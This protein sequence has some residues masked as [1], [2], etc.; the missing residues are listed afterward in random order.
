ML[1]ITN[2]IVMEKWIEVFKAGDYP[3]GKFT[4]AELEEIER[5]KEFY[6]APVVI[7]H[8]KD[9]SPAWGWVKDIKKK[10]DKLLAKI[11]DLV[12]EFVEFLKKG[13]YK[14]V[15][16]RLRKDPER[17]WFL[18]HVG[19]LGGAEPQVKG[20]QTV[21]LN[22]E[23]G[24]QVF[25]I[26]F[27]DFTSPPKLDGIDIAEPKTK[28]DAQGAR[29]RIFEKYG[30]AGLKAYSL[31]Y[32]PDACEK[33]EEGYPACQDAY[34]Y[35]VVDL[36]DGEP[37]IIPKAVSAAL[38][39]AH[40]ARGVKVAENEKKK[41]ETAVKK[42][43]KR[44]KEKYADFVAPE[45]SFDW[46]LERIRDAFIKQNFLRLRTEESDPWIQWIFPDYVIVKDYVSGKYWKVA[47]AI[48]GGEIKFGDPKE[49]VLKERF[50]IEITTED[51]N[52][53]EQTKTG[54]E[55]DKEFEAQLEEERKKIEAEFR[56]KIEREKKV[57]EFLKR[58]EKKIPPVVRE[59]VREV[60][61]AVPEEVEFGEGKKNVREALFEIIEAYPDLSFLFE[62]K[63]EEEKANVREVVKLPEKVKVDPE[64]E[65]IHQKALE[66]MAKDKN[67]TYEQAVKLAL[68]EEV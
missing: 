65:K 58:N 14:H 60:L 62:E 5:N 61:M 6:Q 35:L 56:A 2:L 15:S 34:K 16:V 48:D 17:G 18:V 39:Y 12:P 33:K 32:N 67:L 23:E 26:D 44:I 46:Y 4:E 38:A 52:M 51:V 41:V 30:W 19:F 47:Y 21:E 50:L 20:L 45:G 27:V 1:D 42:L 3:Q 9:S 29:K 66:F 53:G 22:A 24:D 37:K 7:G 43:Q 10:G 54:A 63:K 68:K 31:V 49:I 28:W 40:G 59:K 64:S 11:G 25:E 8:P 55:L 57:D 13:M 36:I